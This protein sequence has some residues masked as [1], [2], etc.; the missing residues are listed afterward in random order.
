MPW[1]ESH[2]NLAR[3]PKTIRLAKALGVSV[4]A[5]VG[6]LHLLWWWALEYAQDGDLTHFSDDEIAEAVLWD[7]DP[8]DLVAGLT[9]AR[10]L[11]DRHIHDWDDYAGR[12]IQKRV[13]NAERMRQARAAREAHSKEERATH[14][15]RTFTARAG[16]TVPNR[17]QHNSTQPDQPGDEVRAAD[18]DAPPAAPP[19]KQKA[20]AKRP[21]GTDLK[22]L[23][24][25]FRAAGL[26]DPKLI[27]NEIAA[28]QALLRHFPPE[29]IVACWQ[30]FCTGARGDS[31]EQSRL[32]F[33][34]LS[35]DNRIGNWQTWRDAGRPHEERTNGTHPRKPAGADPESD[36]GRFAAFRAFESTVPG[37][38][39]QRV[40]AA[41]PRAEPSGVRPR[42]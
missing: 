37:V 18:A 19:P 14:V 7:G 5:A 24:D 9:A 22:P 11:D 35:R 8:G 12:L 28:A 31:F 39:G 32:S 16:A 41:E 34:L 15:Q 2:T 33:G 20:Q 25:A 21:K 36:S 26:P 13:E 27:G 38:S 40:R 1:I 4:P 30:D 10:L 6:H 17:T 29:E 42:G 3:H 23:V